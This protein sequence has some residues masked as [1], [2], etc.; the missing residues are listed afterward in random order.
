MELDSI[1]QAEQELLADRDTITSE[2]TAPDPDGEA[3]QAEP[4]PEDAE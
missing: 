1:E 3:A 2:V 4:S